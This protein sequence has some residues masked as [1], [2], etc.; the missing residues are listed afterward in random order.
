MGLAASQA[1]MLLLVARKSDLEYRGQMINQ[2]R[3][4]LASDTE[5]VAKEYT[6]AISNRVLKYVN[7][8]GKEISVSTANLE[9]NGLAVVTSN[10]T[11]I[12]T[13]TTNASQIEAGLRSGQ[14]Y[15]K[16]YANGKTSGSLISWSSNENFNDKLNTADDAKA[17]ATYAYKSAK[18]QAQDKRLELEL[19]NVDTQHNAVQTEMDAVKKVIE[20]NIE[21]S[22]KTF[23]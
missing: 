8:D 4:K 7:T 23:G 16:S 11:K 17:E 9:S 1:R 13:S 5:Q 2:R 19:K 3:L 21:S 18:L 10:G 14:Y 6:D 20:K 12:D 22:F 15:L